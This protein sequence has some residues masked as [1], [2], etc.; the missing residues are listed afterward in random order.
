MRQGD[1]GDLDAAQHACDFADALILCERLDGAERDAIPGFLA[2]L[3]LPLGARRNLRVLTGVS[4]LR[5]LFEGS[6]AVGV[7]CARAWTA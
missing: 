6:R 7:E 2:D 5:V 4:P 1:V 3:P